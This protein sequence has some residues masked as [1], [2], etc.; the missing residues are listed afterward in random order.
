[1]HVTSL[2]MLVAT[3]R[4]PATRRSGG[5]AI[6]RER[7]DPRT[8]SSTGGAAG[9]IQGCSDPLPLQ[10]R[11]ARNNKAR[12]HHSSFQASASTS[13]GYLHTLVVFFFFYIFVCIIWPCLVSWS[14]RNSI[15]LTAN[16]G[17]K[18][19]QFTKPTSEHP[20]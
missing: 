7:F 3:G 11:A 20:H 17:V 5:A 4:P 8:C 16:Y 10:M 9:Y 19:N 12:I 14:A 15:I 1:M 18:Q 2:C 6:S 13:F